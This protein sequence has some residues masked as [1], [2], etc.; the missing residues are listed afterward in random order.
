MVGR[1]RPWYL[2]HIDE[3]G[4][5]L[6]K[7]R[8]TD[9]SAEEKDF[10]RGEASRVQHFR[11]ALAVGRE[12]ETGADILFRQIGAISPNALVRH[13]A[14]EIFQPVIES[15]AQSADAG[16]SASLARLHCNN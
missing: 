2:I 3:H 14:R 16:F 12:R 15:D 10:R 1:H 13:A 5:N 8:T 7:D 4:P 6:D 11:F 9:R